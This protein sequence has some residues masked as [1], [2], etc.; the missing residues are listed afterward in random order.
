MAVLSAGSPGRWAPL[1]QQHSGN[2]PGCGHPVLTFLFPEALLPFPPL[3]PPLPVKL[4]HRS[5]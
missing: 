5:C 2:M 3:L 1:L 4:G